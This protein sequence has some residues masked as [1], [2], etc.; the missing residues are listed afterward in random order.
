MR[1]AEEQGEGG[2]CPSGPCS[3]SPA[4]TPPPSTPTRHEKPPAPR[5]LCDAAPIESPVT[6]R[7]GELVR[8]ERDGTR[9]DPHE[10]HLASEG[11][12]GGRAWVGG[13]GRA[14]PPEAERALPRLWTACTP[15]QVISGECRCTRVDWD[16]YGA[17]L[18][19]ALRK[20][21]ELVPA[22]ALSLGTPLGSWCER[23]CR[24]VVWCVY[25][26][27][28]GWAARPG[29]GRG[30]GGLVGHED[31]RLG[32]VLPTCRA[33]GELGEREQKKLEAPA[34]ARAVV[35]AQGVVVV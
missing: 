24:R 13:R 12:R 33:A 9:S 31:G 11:G 26:S 1:A 21:E 28:G 7:W 30:R 8:A 19:R 35:S 3:S 27:G 10:R 32:A 34:P 4:S 23:M 6:A 14:A 25:R 20:V 15:K 5:R 2:A 22:T 17:K 16:T 18:A 29:G